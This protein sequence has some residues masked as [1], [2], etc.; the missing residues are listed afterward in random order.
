[1]DPVPQRMAQT[2]SEAAVSI[3]ITSVTDV[4]SFFLGV[5]SPFPSV[6]IFCIYSGLYLKLICFFIFKPKIFFRVEL[7]SDMSRGYQ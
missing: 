2:L 5:I 1:M 7:C 4:A 6:Q 3:T